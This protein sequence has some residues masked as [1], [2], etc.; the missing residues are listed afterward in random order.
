MK[1]YG[2]ALA[3]PVFQTQLTALFPEAMKLYVLAW[4]HRFDVKQCQHLLAS[5]SAGLSYN[6]LEISH[7]SP[8]SFQLLVG[9]SAEYV[10]RSDIG[11]CVQ[12]KGKI[13]KRTLNGDLAKLSQ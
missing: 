2:K 13:Y 4:A 11:L 1:K 8:V 3:Q 10:D 7:S 9:D 5:V 6:H 12:W